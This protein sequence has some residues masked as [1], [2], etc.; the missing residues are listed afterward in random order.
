MAQL[1]R[2]TV[3]GLKNLDRVD[4]PIGKLVAFR[5]PNGAGKTAL[6]QQAP[7]L[8]VLGYDPE[9]G[10]TLGATRQLAAGDGEIVVAGTWADGFGIRRRFGRSLESDVLPPLGERT[11][12]DRQAR[13]NEVTGAFLPSFDLAAF[14]ALSAEKRRDALFKML[15][16]ELAVLDEAE[17][18][19]W[20]GYGT[21]DD[22][23]R[24][25]IEKVWALHLQSAQSPV[26]GLASALAYVHEKMLAAERDR[27]A[28]TKV[29]AAADADAAE[30]T[31]QAPFDAEDLGRLQADLSVAEQTIGRMLRAREDLERTI[32]KASEQAHQFRVVEIQIGEAEAERANQQAIILAATPG[33][34]TASALEEAG[35]RADQKARAQRDAV[36]WA[37]DQH[38]RATA[39]LRAVQERRV[40]LEQERCPVCQSTTGLTFARQAAA[41]DERE[42]EQA[43][44]AAESDLRS[45]EALQEQFD[46]ALEIAFRDRRTATDLNAQRERARLA[47]QGAERRIADLRAEKDRLGAVEPPPPNEIE[48]VQPYQARA[49]ELRDRIRELQVRA[50]LA[51]KAD[52]ER[53]RAD[54]ERKKLDDLTYRSDQLKSLHTGL[55]KYR[56][57]IIERMIEPVATVANGMLQSIDP[58]KQFR[59]VFEREQRDT[60]DFGFEEDGAFRG[61]D[62]ASTGEAAFLAIVFTAGLIAVVK[63]RWRVL[64][65]DN[66]E[67]V[68]DLR[69]RWLLLALAALADHFDN[70]LVA[71]CCDFPDGDAWTVVD[72]ETL[73]P[74]H[75]IGRAA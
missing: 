62:A 22:T 73:R 50:R 33:A 31:V 58:A 48:D 29:V 37:R 8:L 18:R 2:L 61:F 66:V 13:I 38:S 17:Y 9:L 42:A 64:F 49:A 70:V 28:Q 69:R 65:V 53:E 68:D 10:R 57:R 39:D 25:A 56:A 16:R 45:A 19:T 3:T 74:A 51:G 52:A 4:L 6:S 1:T 47:V 43:L 71:G 26:E 44:A 46:E 63:P 40:L 20:L 30:S 59:F 5:G 34:D 21:Q 36:S 7:K 55:Q 75:A 14:L 60:F 27:Q 15:P 23:G 35:R 12:R 54:R 41:A 67:R 32:R 72:M 11:E 24:R